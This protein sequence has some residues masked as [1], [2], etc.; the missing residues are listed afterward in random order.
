MAHDILP[1]ATVLEALLFPEELTPLYLLLPSTCIFLAYF[2]I[3]VE[4]IL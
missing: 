2:L 1:I 3:L 4:H